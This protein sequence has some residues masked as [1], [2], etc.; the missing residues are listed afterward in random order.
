LNNTAKQNKLF[1]T[2]GGL[3]SIDKLM[4]TKKV[5]QIKNRLREVL[6]EKDTL[7]NGSVPFQT[8]Q[9]LLQSCRITL[10]DKDWKFIH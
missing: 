7:L 3:N 2:R 5:F 9:T 10:S 1:Q 8:F 4:D 6:R